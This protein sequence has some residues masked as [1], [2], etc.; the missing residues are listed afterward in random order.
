MAMSNQLVLSENNNVLSLAAHKWLR[1][2]GQYAPQHYLHLLT[3]AS[4]VWRTG[5]MASGRAAT[6]QP[7]NSR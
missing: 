5:S 1:E 3:L 4:G 2:A 6:G 7:S